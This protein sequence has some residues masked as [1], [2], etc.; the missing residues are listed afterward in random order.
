MMQTRIVAFEMKLLKSSH[1]KIV[2]KQRWKNH[3]NII[4]RV[5]KETERLQFWVRMKK[6]LYKLYE[7]NEYLTFTILHSYTFALDLKTH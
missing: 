6:S 2:S 5:R 3:Q 1:E 7:L 4:S